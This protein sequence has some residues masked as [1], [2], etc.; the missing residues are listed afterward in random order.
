M[1]E[2]LLNSEYLKYIT[3]VDLSNKNNMLTKVDCVDGIGD[4]SIGTAEAELGYAKL[5]GQGTT[6]TGNYKY[7]TFNNGWHSRDSFISAV[8]KDIEVIEK[9]AF[10]KINNSITKKDIIGWEIIQVKDLDF[11]TS[12]FRQ[13]FTTMPEAWV[14]KFDLYVEVI[15]QELCVYVSPDYDRYIAGDEELIEAVEKILRSERDYIKLDNET[16]NELLGEINKLTFVDRSNLGNNNSG[17]WWNGS[18]GTIWNKTFYDIDTSLSIDNN[19]N[20]ITT[21]ISSTGK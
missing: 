3:S 6:S 18:S 8:A 17:T 4:N 21:A 13:C 16:F 9:E 15:S 7:T 20:S 5:R 10:F 14:S 11:L 2:E 19:G 12:N 1:N